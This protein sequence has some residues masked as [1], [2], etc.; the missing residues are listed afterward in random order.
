VHPSSPGLPRFVHF[1]YPV[2]SFHPKE[3]SDIGIFT[4]N[5]ELWNDYTKTPFSFKVN[6]TNQ[7]PYL[8]EGKIS[9]LKVPIISDFTFNFS[10]GFDREGQ[11]IKFEANERYK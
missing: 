4:I 11:K 3:P 5:G 6:V 8:L 1:D 10:K 9:D 7:A 2:Y